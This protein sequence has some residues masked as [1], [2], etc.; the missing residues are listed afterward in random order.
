MTPLL[1]PVFFVYAPKV[2]GGG[3]GAALEAARTCAKTVMPVPAM[4]C[5][6]AYVGTNFIHQQSIKFIK[7]VTKSASDGSFLGSMKTEVSN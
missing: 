7:I 5:P 2:S 1:L 4:P 3:G 6:A